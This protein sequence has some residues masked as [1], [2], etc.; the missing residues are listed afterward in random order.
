MI[1]LPKEKPVIEE[2]N[3]YYVDIH[4]LFEHYQGEIG[5][6]GIYFQ[7]PGA[8]GALFFDQDELL[9]GCFQDKV[10]EMSGKEAIDRL[11]EAALD[12][13]FI[14][15]VYQFDSE[16]VY[17]WANI[18]LAKRIYKDL[19]TEFTD[20]DGLI[21][22]M[23]SEK[24]TGYIDVSIGKGNESGLIFFND[25]ICIGGSYSW[26]EG[27]LSSSKESQH[28]LIK[29]TKKFGGIFHVSRIPMPTA[30]VAKPSRETAPAENAATILTIIGE[31][32]EAFENLV[33]TNKRIK[34]DFGSLLKKKFIDNAEK[35]SF[36]DPFAAEFEYLNREIAFYGDASDRELAT[37]VAACVVELAEDLGMLPR[38]RDKLGLW[39]GK[40][41]EQIDKFGIRI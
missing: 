37:G 15:S 6:G 33:E 35:Y 10:G 18:P 7:S 8:E 26:G 13:N 34:V 38:L 22:K 9:N 20:L 14:I 1:I 19:S 12:H 17:F 40:Y 28:L 39:Q 3:S 32:L 41:A 24:L 31:L 23:G 29:K 4:K 16:M 25:G 11:T 2:L 5:S 30:G 21:K 27:E 36:L